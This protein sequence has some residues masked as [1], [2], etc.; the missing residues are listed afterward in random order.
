MK[1][2]TLFALSLSLCI[3]AAVPPASAQDKAPGTGGGAK[4]PAAAKPEATGLEKLS[5]DWPAWLKVGLL[6]RGRVESQRPVTGKDPSYDGYYLNRLRLSATVR[7]GAWLQVVTQ[8]QD[9]E[10]MG[11]ATSPAP[12]SMAGGFDLRQGYVEIGRKGPR[13]LVVAGGRQEFTLGDSRLIASPDWGNSSRTYDMGRVSGTL[14]GLKVDVFR[15]APVDV[16]PAKFDRVKPGEYFWGGYSTLDRVKHLTAVDLY[17]VQKATSVATGELGSRGDGRVNTFGARVA[18]PLARGVSFDFESALQRGHLA[19]D[20]VSGWAFHAGVAWT[21]PKRSLKPRLAGEYNYA[22]G[23]DKPKD[24][25]RQTFDQLYA[26]NHARY[27]LA[28]LIGWRNMHAATVKLDVAPSKRVKVT[29]ALNGLWLATVADAWYGSSGSKVVTNAKA[30]SRHVGWEPD[31]LASF[32]VSKE[33]TLGAGLALL[34][35]GEYVKQSTSLERY[36]FPY[37]TWTL[38]F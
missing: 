17:A 7:G 10:A 2:Q 33:M 1:R 26:S 11:Y 23:D 20:S 22:S 3:F 35:P 4:A 36:W 5:P 16:D 31:L 6:Y 27:G 8:I 25:T 28:D 32:A 21:A 29:G 30:T 19:A 12:K 18:G 9:V 14:P 34:L 24:G 15:A 37:A 38:K 13:G